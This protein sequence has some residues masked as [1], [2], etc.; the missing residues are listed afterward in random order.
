MCFF[1]KVSTVS[2]KVAEYSRICRLGGGRE[3][4]LSSTPLTFWLSSLSPSSNTNVLHLFLPEGYDP[5]GRGHS[6]VNL[7]VDPHDVVLQV[8]VVCGDYNLDAQVLGH[9]NDDLGGL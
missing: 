8:G 2:G 3:V 6:P 4:T 9:L 1:L 5:A 7:L